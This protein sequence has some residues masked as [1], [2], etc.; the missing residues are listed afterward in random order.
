M[1]DRPVRPEL[2]PLASRLREA[3]RAI[4]TQLEA[5]DVAQV[6]VQQ[7]RRYV[8]GRNPPPIDVVT[9]IAVAAGY[10]VEW[11]LTGEGPARRPSAP[12]RTVTTRDEMQEIFSSPVA[13]AAF[14]T[15]HPERMRLLEE[16][17]AQVR[18]MHERHRATSELL[19]ASGVVQVLR[20]LRAPIGEEHTQDA[21][22]RLSD[23]VGEGPR[24]AWADRARM[25]Y[26]V[27][28]IALR[29]LRFPEGAAD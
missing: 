11:I 28:F 15:E 8:S 14:A 10:H 25:S 3:M 1:T 18:D 23:V 6:S 16:R 22:D 24:E 27:L 19:R 13:Q 4:G 7:V 9:R 26:E 17:A 29:Y 5:A 21:L 12:S 2:L 20:H